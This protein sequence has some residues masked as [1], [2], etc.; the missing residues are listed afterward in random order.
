MGAGERGTPDGGADTRPGVRKQQQQHGRRQ[1]R[2]VDVLPGGQQQLEMAAVGGTAAAREAGGT[3]G[4]QGGGGKLDWVCVCVCVCLERGGT[5]TRNQWMDGWTEGGMDEGERRAE[6]RGAK[7]GNWMEQ[8]GV[9]DRPVHPA[10]WDWTLEQ[11]DDAGEAQASRR[12]GSCRARWSLVARETPQ[13]ARLGG[14][15]A[16][17]SGVALPGV[18]TAPG[19][20]GGPGTALAWPVTGNAGVDDVTE[21]SLKPE[22]LGQQAGA[23]GAAGLEPTGLERG[24]AGPPCFCPTETGQ[25]F[26]RIPRMDP[27]NPTPSPRNWSA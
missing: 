9:T 12:R 24:G 7:Q 25:L 8:A 10:L 21:R 15:L 4:G 11:Q 27:P 17:R 13:L 14:Q 19:G 5:E 26:A 16:A 23:A 18:Q 1:R 3:A 22:R 6:R 20:P 2:L